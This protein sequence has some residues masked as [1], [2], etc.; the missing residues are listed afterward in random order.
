MAL[1]VEE[2]EAEIDRLRHQIERSGTISFLDESIAADVVKELA[3]GRKLSA[4]AVK[5]RAS[6]MHGDGGNL[7]LQVTPKGRSWLF[8]YRWGGKQREM[9]LG[10]VAE[11]PLGEARGRAAICRRLVRQRVDPIERRRDLSAAAS[12]V[13][14]AKVTF[15]QAA[16]RYI[17]AHRASWK[18]PKHAA[19]WDMTIGPQDPDEKGDAR[20]WAD[21]ERNARMKALRSLS[22]D[23]VQTDDVLKIIEP[24]WHPLPETASRVRGR[25]E[26]VLDWSKARGQRQGDNPA[27]WRGHLD[28]LLPARS[29]VQKVQHHAALAWRDMNAFWSNLQ[30]REG[31]SFEALRFTI[32][33]AARTGEVIGARWD[34]I[35]LEEEIWTIPADRMKAGKEHRVPL[36]GE[37]LDVLRRMKL[38]ASDK[39]PFVFP[40]QRTGR[41]LS[42][43]AM[44]TSLKNMGRG[45][46]TTHGFRSAFRDWASESTAY[47]SELV[48]MALAHA[49]SNKVE[50][51]YRRGDMFEKRRRLMDDWAKHCLTKPAL[52]TSNVH[53]IGEARA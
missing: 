14:P 23:R 32:L 37:T 46:L 40:G 31:V 26:A 47:A 7:W 42:N 11:V 28:K 50:A 33:T 19:Q 22:V 20:G 44:L 25:I 52:R 41:A 5:T 12:A 6:G 36:S 10:A 1:S 13:K 30:G 21:P 34:E 3:V 9:G 17:A 53:A 43:M 2:L 38:L 51:A 35:D 24:L 39:Q 18:N 45:D 8:R 4:T 27:R 49:I 15:A 16:D 29:K 48:E